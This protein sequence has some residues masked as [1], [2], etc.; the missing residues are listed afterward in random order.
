MG[1][2]RWIVPEDRTVFLSVFAVAGFAAIRTPVCH[3]LF[4]SHSGCRGW[5]G[6]PHRATSLM[7]QSGERL[8]LAGRPPG[9]FRSLID[10]HIFG[11]KFCHK[12]WV[13]IIRRVREGQL[14]LRVP[15]PNLLSKYAGAGSASRVQVWTVSAS[16]E[17]TC[18]SR[19]L[20]RPATNMIYPNQRQVKKLAE[21][22][23]IP[24]IY[25]LLTPGTAYDIIYNVESEK[26][27]RKRPGDPGRRMR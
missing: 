8:R 23:D 24:P 14:I 18:Q 5:I 10:R 25:C 21:T 26:Q 15:F 19:C 6:Q 2:K 17:P 9:S 13:V 3:F 7:H 11:C 27:A 22:A 12:P 20:T 1:A 16:F 4:S